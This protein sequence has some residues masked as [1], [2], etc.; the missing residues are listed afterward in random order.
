MKTLQEGLVHQ[1]LPY[2]GICF[3][4]RGLWLTVVI[5]K[6]FIQACFLSFAASLVVFIC[7]LWSHEDLMVSTLEERAASGT[8]NMVPS[9]HW[10][11]PLRS[12]ET[13]Q[14]TFTETRWSLRSRLLPSE[15]L[16]CASA[17]FESEYQIL[18]K[19]RGIPRVYWEKDKAFNHYLFTRSPLSV[20]SVL[21]WQYP[22]LASFFTC[23]NVRY[24]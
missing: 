17:I 15:L 20:L 16:H 3:I 13:W 7:L 23:V 18:L 14:G 4:L 12:R 10:H 24:A 19:Q 2:W 11:F 22:C 1:A 8:L 21:F 9:V 5:R 6:Y